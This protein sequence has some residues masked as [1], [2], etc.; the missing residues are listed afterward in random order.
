[1]NPQPALQKFFYPSEIIDDNFNFYL[2]SVSGIKSALFVIKLK[3]QIKEVD[4]PIR[5]G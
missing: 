2:K 1:M 3:A 5:E 4:L